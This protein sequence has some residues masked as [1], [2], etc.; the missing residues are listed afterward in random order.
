MY[1]SI[2]IILVNHIIYGHYDCFITI[3]ADMIIKY[4]LF[5]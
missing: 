4:T 2:K 3:K 1:L 5:K